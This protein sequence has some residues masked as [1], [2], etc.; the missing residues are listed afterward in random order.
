MVAKQR[1]GT[2]RVRGVQQATAQEDLD[3]TLR[4]REDPTAHPPL[5]LDAPEG[6]RFKAPAR[7]AVAVTGDPVLP[8]EE[9]LEDRE[10]WGAAA[11]LARE[12]WGPPPGVQDTE[13]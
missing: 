13:E 9:V 3:E 12:R 8:T 6:R 5:D 2:L 7:V 4:V 1:E 10:E 11:G